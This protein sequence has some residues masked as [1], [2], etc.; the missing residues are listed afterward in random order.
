MKIHLFEEQMQIEEHKKELKTKEIYVNKQQMLELPIFIF[1]KAL[2]LQLKKDGK[3]IEIL[4]LK[5]CKHCGRLFKT[6]CIC[7]QSRQSPVDRDIDFQKTLNEVREVSEQNYNNDLIKTKI[8]ED[9]SYPN[10]EELL[11][12]PI[13]DFNI[14]LID[15]LKEDGFEYKIPELKTCE[16]GRKYGV[17]CICK[18]IGGYVKQEI[19]DN[20][21]MSERL[22]SELH[23]QSDMN[24]FK[25]NHI[26]Q[27]QGV[28]LFMDEATHIKHNYHIGIDKGIDKKRPGQST[29]LVDMYI[30]C[31][32]D[33]T[34]KIVYIE[35]HFV[36][37]NIEI[38]AKANQC[39]LRRILKR[40][41]NEHSNSFDSISYIDNI[42]ENDFSI[43]L[44]Q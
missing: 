3:G 43:R 2:E 37:D 24:E 44:V 41:Y 34:G 11:G 22:K 20:N 31:I 39:L 9:K 1:N 40:L 26:L 33:N 29:R 5:K 12:L 38:Q 25:E 32:F 27:T 36:S 23:S 8:K 30:Q 4:D 14:L 17:V 10:K 7:K 6:F 21:K 42:N 13:E 28:K 16:C 35:D 15:H 18:Q 19:Q